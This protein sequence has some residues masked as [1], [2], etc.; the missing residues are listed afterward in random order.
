MARILL[1]AKAD[2]NLPS[3]NG[4]TPLIVVAITT[5]T[6]SS[7]LFLLERGANPNHADRFWKRTPLYAAVEMRESWISRANRRRRS[8][9]A[10]DPMDLIKAL[11]AKGANPNARVNTTPVRGFMQGSAN[12][13]NFDG[14][15][16]FIQSGACRRHHADA[17]V[18]RTW[19]RSEHQDQRR[20]DGPDGGRRREL[21]RQPDLQPLQ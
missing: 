17:T 15:T 11:L 2:I 16:A 6:S 13:V 20:L 1:D 4:S 8:A 19:R 7:R 10:G 18:A 3:A 5:I 9:D 14:Q 21:G 12:W